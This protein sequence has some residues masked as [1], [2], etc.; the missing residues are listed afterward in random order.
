MEG[1]GA[2]VIRGIDWKWG[3]QD[4]GEG[5]VGTGKSVLKQKISAKINIENTE[6]PG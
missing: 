1:V 2:R 4:G 5:H 6:K 3:K